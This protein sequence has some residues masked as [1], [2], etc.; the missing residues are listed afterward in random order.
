MASD[1]ENRIFF[2]GGGGAG[3]GNNSASNDGG[4]GGGIAF[5]VAKTFIGTGNIKADGANGLNTV[6]AGNDAPGG[7]GGGGTIVIKA[8]TLNNQTVSSNGG[9]GGNQIITG[10][11]AEGCGGGGGGGVIATPPNGAGTCGITSS[12]IYISGKSGLT[13]SNALTEFPP[14]GGTWGAEGEY[15]VKVSPGFI[16]YT[17]TCLVDLDGDNI[18]DRSDD[19]DID[20][21]GI[22]IQ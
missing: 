15:D 5:V 7:G 8:N 20:N 4:D 12:Y 1:V 9:N 19:L 13:T 17:I 16:P 22:Y 10:P 3:D 6:G 18:D 14:N 21:D 11:E 2:G